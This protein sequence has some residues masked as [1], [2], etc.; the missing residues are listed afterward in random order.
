MTENDGPIKPIEIPRSLDELSEILSLLGNLTRLRVIAALS[1]RP[2]FIQELSSEL[3]VSYP[4]LHLH[5]KNMEKHGLV[6]SEYA[7]GTDKSTRY[8]KR[9]FTLVDFR[10]EITADLI[11]RLADTDSATKTRKKGKSTKR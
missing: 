1:K 9:Y 6:K 3:K 4:L 5:L 2:M 8:V 11:A 7:V 10:L